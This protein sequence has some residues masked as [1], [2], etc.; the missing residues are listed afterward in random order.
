MTNSNL[1]ILRTYLRHGVKVLLLRDFRLQFGKFGILWLFLF[2]FRPH[3]KT[4]DRGAKHCV[5][6]PLDRRI[7]AAPCAIGST[8]ERKAS[9]E[10]LIHAICIV[11][12][13]SLAFVGSYVR[14]DL[15]AISHQYLVGSMST[16]VV[17]IPVNGNPLQYSSSQ[18]LITWTRWHGILSCWNIPSLGTWRDEIVTK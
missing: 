16:N 17:A 4:R 6:F 14:M 15:S 12:H 3:A 5:E 8:S 18:L 10:M 1:P 7:T 2:S 13:S 11:A 9:G